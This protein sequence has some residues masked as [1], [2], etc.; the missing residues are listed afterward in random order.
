[1]PSFTEPGKWYFAVSCLACEM[2]IPLAEAPSPADRPDPLK[3]RIMSG[4]RCPHCDHVGVY[5]PNMIT[6]R[7][8]V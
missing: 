7:P 2:P 3:Y 4:V 5:A 1:M 8:V 6:R